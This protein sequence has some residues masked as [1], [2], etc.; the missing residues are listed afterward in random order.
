MY[1]GWNGSVVSRAARV[2]LAAAIVVGGM[3]NS[4]AAGGKRTFRRETVQGQAQATAG[5]A[6]RFAVDTPELR[7][8]FI[9]SAQWLA[10][11]EHQSLYTFKGKP[12]RQAIDYLVKNQRR[13]GSWSG[14]GLND[15]GSFDDQCT[16]TALRALLEWYAET[17]DESVVPAAKKCIDLLLRTQGQVLEPRGTAS[18]G[19]PFALR[20]GGLWRMVPDPKEWKE[21]WWSHLDHE[22][23]IGD[24][25]TSSHANALMMAYA[26]FGDER[27]KEAVVACARSLQRLQA[28]HGG[29]LPEHVGPRGEAMHGRPHEIPAWS[30]RAVSYAIDVYVD[31]HRVS[32]DARW[33][34]AAR[35][36]ADW[37]APLK[38]SD[39]PVRFQNQGP[40]IMWPS[41]VEM[42]TLRPV[43]GNKFGQAVYSVEEAVNPYGWWHAYPAAAIDKAKRYFVQHAQ[44]W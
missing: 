4:A 36:S 35:K 20:V 10:W 33:A 30:T 6:S 13:D 8:G 19:G 9:G 31:A 26:V 23:N 41:L 24:Q 29:G 38:L 22:W 17:G 27:C 12:A 14:E 40:Q 28:L 34:M 39:Q 43:Y 2:C 21:D 16:A 3:A 15:R 11:A 18:D 42:H 32:H 25:V 44:R 5:A 1:V 37:V 7:S